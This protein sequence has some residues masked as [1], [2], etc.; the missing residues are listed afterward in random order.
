MLNQLDAAC[1]KYDRMLSKFLEDSEPQT[2]FNQYMQRIAWLY[3]YLSEH[4]GEVSSLTLWCE[5]G[6]QFSVKSWVFSCFDLSQ[7]VTELHQITRLEDTLSVQASNN[8]KLPAWTNPIYP[9]LL[10]DVKV[11]R[12]QLYTETPYMTR[13]RGGPFLTDVFHQMQRKQRGELSRKIAIYSAHDDTL[14]NVMKALNVINQ[15]TVTPG[16]GAALALELHCSPDMECIVKVSRLRQSTKSEPALFWFLLHSNRFSTTS[17]RTINS[18]NG[19]QF[20]V[21]RI[22]AV[23]IASGMRFVTI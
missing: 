15:T 19:W 1:P 21:V 20:P 22:R 9:D 5:I 23:S 8:L 3:K 17:I 10:H 18:R 7:N 11:R 16:Y 2:E 14:S 12:F 4:S 13:I 6:R